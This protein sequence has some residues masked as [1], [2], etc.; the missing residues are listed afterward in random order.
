MDGPWSIYFPKV[1]KRKEEKRKRVV[2]VT[3]MSE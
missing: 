2:Y 1:R 3:L